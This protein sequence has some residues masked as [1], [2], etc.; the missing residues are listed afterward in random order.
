MIKDP[1]YIFLDV[2]PDVP[3]EKFPSK[4]ECCKFEY[5]KMAQLCE[6]AEKKGLGRSKAC[7]AFG[8]DR[9]KYLVVSERMARAVKHKSLPRKY[10]LSSVAIEYLAENGV[11]EW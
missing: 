6:I 8:G 3:E 2:D 5:I 1:N 7:N 9:G 10:V 11:F 4:Q